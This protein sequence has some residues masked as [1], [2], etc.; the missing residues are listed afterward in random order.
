MKEQD[1]HK[2][3]QY[4]DNDIT[5]SERAQVQKRATDDAA[6]HAELETRQRLHHALQQIEAEQPSMRFAVN[7]MDKLPQLYKK[8]VV[9]PLVNP[10]W[11]RGF[12]YLLAALGLVYTGAVVQYV[13]STEGTSSLPG[14]EF[15]SGL[16]TAIPSQLWVMMAT[17]CASYL[18][19]VWLD[20]QLKK[21]FGRKT[22][23]AESAKKINQ[24]K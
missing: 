21:R 6:F 17:L 13:Q 22:P 5:S 23:R 9:Q 7:V 3:W 10:L 11:V 12:F 1:I 19:F 4:L 18:A 24:I 8:I 14:V 2:I 20:R 16:L 15:L